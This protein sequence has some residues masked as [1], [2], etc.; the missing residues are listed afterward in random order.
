[1]CCGHGECKL[2]DQQV[3]Q[4]ARAVVEAFGGRQRPASPSRRRRAERLTQTAEMFARDYVAEMFA[5]DYV[6]ELFN[7]PDYRAWRQVVDALGSGRDRYYASPLAT[8]RREWREG[9]EQHLEETACAAGVERRG[10]SVDE[11][12]A[13]RRDTNLERRVTRA[14]GPRR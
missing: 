2:T 3:R 14:G 1:V 11:Y 13:C 7:D 8:I 9:Y 4:A 5:R 6:A 12:L 10:G